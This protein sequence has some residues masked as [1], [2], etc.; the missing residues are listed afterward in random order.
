MWKSSTGELEQCGKEIKEGMGRVSGSYTYN[1]MVF[2]TE[3]ETRLL[4]GLP[5]ILRPGL[6]PKIFGFWVL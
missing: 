5:I 2:K 1:K 6:D 3:K 4:Y